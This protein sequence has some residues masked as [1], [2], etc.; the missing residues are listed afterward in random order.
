MN[1]YVVAGIIHASIIHANTEEDARK[2][3]QKRY[4]WENILHLKKTSSA[5]N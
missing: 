5:N 1:I 4:K 2:L 3:F